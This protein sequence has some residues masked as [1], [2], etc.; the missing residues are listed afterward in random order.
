MVH[1]RSFWAEEVANAKGLRK[2]HGCCSQRKTRKPQWQRP[3][4]CRKEK[5]RGKHGVME[6]TDF[7][8]S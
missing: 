7:T 4:E 1:R 5:G 3:I 6:N 2:D 8:P